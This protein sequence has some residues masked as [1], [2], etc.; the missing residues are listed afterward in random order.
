MNKRSLGALI[1]L[2]LVLLVALVVVGL[3]PQPA[4]AQFA[5]RGD[6]MMIAGAVA[7]REAQA[8]VYI[9]ER[10]TQRM[11]ALMFRSSDNQFE[12]IAGRD[13]AGDVLGGGGS[14]GGRR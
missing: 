10:N 2:N 5:A 8:S 12:V 4:A 3:T 9:I 6:Y 13:V 11:L 1:A 7:G 14:G